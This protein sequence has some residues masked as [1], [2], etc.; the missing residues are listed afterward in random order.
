MVFSIQAEDQTAETAAEVKEDIAITADKTQGDAIPSVE[1]NIEMGTIEQS[2]NHS[3]RSVIQN[4]EFKIVDDKSTI[5]VTFSEM[6]KYQ[7]SVNATLKQ[8]AYYFENTQTPNRLQRAYDTTEFLSTVSLFTLLEM[9]SKEGVSKLVIQLKDGK[10]P[11]A[12]V[13]GNVLTIGFEGIK[14]SSEKSLT[15]NES[16]ELIEENIYSSNKIFSGKNIELELKNSDVQDALRFIAKTSG[17]NIVVGED[18]TGKIGTLSLKNVPWDQAFTLILQAK[19]LGYVKQ[20]NVIRVATLTSLKAE[21]DAA[22]ANEQSKVKV[23]TLKTVLIPVSYAKASELAPR[24][25]NLLTER[26]TAET[27]VRTNSIII[28]DVEKVV[29]KAQ[30]LLTALDTQ[31]PRVSISAKIV[32]VASTYTRQLG[33]PKLGGGVPTSFN[34]VNYTAGAKLDGGTQ[35]G[36]FSIF[37]LQEQTQVLLFQLGELEEKVKVLANPT[38]SV[39]ANQ[40]A[41]INQTFSFFVSAT[42]TIA[43]VTVA[44]VKQIS[45]NLSLDVTPIV[46]GDGSIFMT[47]NIKNEVPKGSG[48]NTTIDTRN[49][50]TQ[51]LLENGDTAVIGGI[52]SNTVKTG[53]E[54]IPGLMR[55]PILGYLFSR[56]N[57]EDIKNEVFVFLTA[58]ILNAEEAFKRNL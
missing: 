40:Q 25:K 29:V 58:K 45:S 52:F 4:I 7:Q 18:V 6:P 30:K 37:A 19:K 15:Q 57:L 48:V 16:N 26:G 23:E 41:S 43:G 27:D 49:V 53:K 11:Q 34:G 46:S 51:V 54:G 2:K 9:P 8:V 28:R 44:S 21:K 42:E 17:F 32:E 38:V 22:L 13:S 1:E 36:A 55:I 14:G 35:G 56:N 33:M 5:Q 10:K 3:K 47:L 24:V 39:V 20:G 31:P 12:S 50:S